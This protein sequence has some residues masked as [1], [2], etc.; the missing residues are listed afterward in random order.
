MERSGGEEE[1]RHHIRERER[2][3]ESRGLCTGVGRGLTT[4]GH[5]GLSFLL[6]LHVGPHLEKSE[7]ILLKWVVYSSTTMC[8]Y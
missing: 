6:M 1:G 2:Q 5:S 3:G 4:Y 7:V 8:Q